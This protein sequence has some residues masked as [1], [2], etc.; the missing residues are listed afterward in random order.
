MIRGLCCC[1]QPQLP[2]TIQFC[3]VVSSS[4]LTAL[5]GVLQV[6]ARLHGVVKKQ[7]SVH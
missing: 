2:I 4:C 7:A 6:A 5:V 3:V 1:D